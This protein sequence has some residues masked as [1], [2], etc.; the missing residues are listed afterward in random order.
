M[1]GL[2]LLDD[3]DDGCCL[4]FVAF[5]AADL[6]WEPAAVNEQADDDLGVNAAFLGVADLAQF[7]FLFRLE[8]QRLC[9]CRH[10]SVV[11]S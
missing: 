1:A 7:V 5:E 11:T 10:N 2:E 9:R 4:C 3:R 6:K 8:I